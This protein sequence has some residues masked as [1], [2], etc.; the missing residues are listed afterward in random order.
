MNDNQRVAIAAAIGTVAV[1]GLYAGIQHW[2]AKW[3]AVHV[4]ALEAE[5][6][7]L[8]ERLGRERY[9]LNLLQS[10][11]DVDTIALSKARRIWDAMD[12]DLRAVIIRQ[13]EH[14]T[15]EEL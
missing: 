4:R 3:M 14:Q 12:P 15:T 11:G 8:R 10:G 7:S 1:A 2:R 13:Q 6:K 5:S 9:C